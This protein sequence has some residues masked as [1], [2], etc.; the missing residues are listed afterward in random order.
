MPF[1]TESSTVASSADGGA[2]RRPGRRL[3][4]RV[5]HSVVVVHVVASVSWLALMLCLLTLGTTALATHDADTV[6]TAYRAMGMLGDALIIPLSLLTLVSGVVLAVG[7]PW[8]LFRFYWV[9][10]KLWLTLVATV[11][12]VF[13]LTARLHDAVHAVALHPA[14]P[15]SA[16]HLG[17]IRYNMVIVPA[18]AL[19]LYL[20]NVVLS[21]F[22]P[23]GR[24][25]AGGSGTG[26][27]RRRVRVISRGR[28]PG[29][30]LRR[31]RGAR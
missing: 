27:R 29:L 10:T 21:V 14:G 25:S 1:S 4:V 11:A 28:R 24:R 31:V 12:S 8:G 16:M 2:L 6:R 7:T 13:A 30:S 15:V 3:S 17:F 9:G 5:R 19:L 23:W 20:A 22:K 18:V 26:Q